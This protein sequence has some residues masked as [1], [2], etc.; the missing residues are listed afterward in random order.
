MST[1]GILIEQTISIFIILVL[2]VICYKTKLIDDT[3]NSKL[4]NILLTLVQPTLIFTSFQREFNIDL[5][6]G[7]II[8]L[9]LALITHIVAISISYIFIRRKKKKIIVVDGVRT[10]TYVENKDVDVERLTSGYANMGFIGIPL[11]Y[12]LYGSEGVFY[13]TASVMTFNILM[14]THGVIMISGTK[15]LKF[16]DIL[17]RLKSPAIIAIFLG[18]IVFIFQIRLPNVLNQSLNYIGSINTP[19]GMLI[20]GATIAKTDIVKMFIG[21]LRKYYMVFLKLLFIPFVLMLIY[22]RLPI[23]DTLK[24]IAIIMAATPTTT[25]GTILTIR[26]KKN[27]VLAAEIF[28]MTTLLCVFTIPFIIKVAELLM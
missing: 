25:I 27:S 6:E 22:V 7:L 18:L 21:N 28:A 2:G 26:Y 11:A 23:D 12:G 15:E 5:V 20:A 9:V 24:M 17:M 13:V 19:F 14:W 10:V 4:S 16:K 8:S 1:S 3:T